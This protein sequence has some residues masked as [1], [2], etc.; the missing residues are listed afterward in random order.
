[1]TVVRRCVNNVTLKLLFHCQAFFFLFGFDSNIEILVKMFVSTHTHTHARV[2]LH[3]LSYKM[4][5]T[6]RSSLTHSLTHTH[7]IEGVA[8]N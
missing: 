3:T 4:S 2:T 5:M 7:F 6:G 1:M 8:Y